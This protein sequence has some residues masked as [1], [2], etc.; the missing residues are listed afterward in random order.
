[1]DIPIL[2]LYGAALFWTLGYDTVYAHQDTKDD[3]HLGIGS[4]ALLWGENTPHFLFLS[5]GMSLVLFLFFGHL[6]LF[7]F[8]YFFMILLLFLHFL[9]QV[10]TLRLGDPARCLLL[11]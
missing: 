11:F 8:P 9:W 7:G 3:Q 1:I 6:M 4:T 10:V 2:C 5:Y